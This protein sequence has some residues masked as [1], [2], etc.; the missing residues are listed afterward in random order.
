M[1]TLYLNVMKT[2]GWAVWERMSCGDTDMVCA[3]NNIKYAYMDDSES[4]T[5]LAAFFSPTDMTIYV[6]PWFVSHWNA[7]MIGFILWHELTHVKQ[8]YDFG[9]ELVNA[10]DEGVRRNVT[11]RIK[12]W[13]RDEKYHHGR[14]FQKCMK[15]CP[16]T[17]E[18][19]NAWVDTQA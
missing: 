16:V 19:F 17:E 14:S 3:Y 10:S 6:H 18:Q 7:E 1:D 8:M 15:Q 5:N 11:R 13:I 9:R 2:A 12:R 4:N